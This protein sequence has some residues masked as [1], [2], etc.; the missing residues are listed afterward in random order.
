[1]GDGWRPRGRLSTPSLVLRLPGDS[2]LI[3]L[4]GLLETGRQP[5]N[6]RAAEPRKVVGE[7]VACSRRRT[8]SISRLS[9]VRVFV[10]E[11]L[12]VQWLAGLLDDRVTLD[13]LRSEVDADQQ[14]TCLPLIEFSARTTFVICLLRSATYSTSFSCR[15]SLSS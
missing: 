7:V 11:T 1:M 8:E 9:N 5:T 4:T 10:I 13:D 6:D 3:E 12:N 2:T 15:S 14:C